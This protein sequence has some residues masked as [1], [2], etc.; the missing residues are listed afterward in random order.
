M[1]HNIT[2][3]QKDKSWQFIISYKDENGKWKQKSKQGFKS[4]REAKPFA[5]EMLKKIEG[6]MIVTDQLDD[7]YKGI[8]FKDF[9]DKFIEHEK[10]YRAASSINLY[11]SIHRTFSQLDKI[12][13]SE[14]TYL[15]I[16][17]CIDML[18]KRGLMEVTISD[19]I[20][21]LN[22]FFKSAKNKYKLINENPVSNI[23]KPKKEIR[24][25]KRA[26]TLSE[27]NGLLNN[28]TYRPYYIMSL[29]AGKCGLRVGEIIGLR[30][31]DIDEKR[32]VLKVDHQWKI[33]NKCEYGF[34]TL[35]SI[36]SNREVPLS[37]NV[38]SEL[39]KYKKETPTNID[40]R[41]FTNRSS[42]ISFKIARHFKKCGYDISIHELRHTYATMLIA[43]GVDFKTAAKLL[44]HDVKQTMDTYSH[45]TDDM[46]EKASILVNSIF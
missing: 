11:K 41:I 40:G 43:N 15:D 30:W 37:S 14:I 12:V 2:Y 36:N 42:N 39:L 3:R 34:G 18:V 31:S 23:D 44:G 19:Y 26:L 33:L 25:E 21:K 13:M 16:Q 1:D 8:T 29:I 17:S 10:L 27:L 5:D 35:K 4:K 46:L 6:D 24:R 45:V 20:S 9:V 7:E 28:I 22:K 32:C 38:L